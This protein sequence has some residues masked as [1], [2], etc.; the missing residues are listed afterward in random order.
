MDPCESILAKIS[1]LPKGGDERTRAATAYEL[2]QLKK[3]YAGCLAAAQQFHATLD[4][5]VTMIAKGPEINARVSVDI[6]LQLTFNVAHTGVNPLKAVLLDPKE[7]VEAVLMANDVGSFAWIAKGDG[8]LIL[9]VLLRLDY[10]RSGM[11]SSMAVSSVVLSTDHVNDL[12]RGSRMDERGNVRLVGSG[13][14]ERP[15]NT[16]SLLVAGTLDPRP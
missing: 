7:R 10:Q 8:R 9:P 4:S 16:C 14:F 13:T 6:R 15:G 5:N 11:P 1:A 2:E 3:D 12:G